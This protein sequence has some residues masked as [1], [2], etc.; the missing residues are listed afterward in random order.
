MALFLAQADYTPFELANYIKSMSTLIYLDFAIND[1]DGNTNK[2]VLDNAVSQGF[3]VQQ[4]ETGTP[5]NI[6]FTQPEDGQPLWIFGGGQFTNTAPALVPSSLLLL[7][8][9]LLA[10]IPYQ[11]FPCFNSFMMYV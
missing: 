4:A 9:L 3:K 2:S 10:A 7:L 11:I 6:L 1:T 5:V 8:P